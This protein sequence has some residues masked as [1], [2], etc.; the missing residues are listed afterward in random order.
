MPY[1]VE[2]DAF[3]G[4]VLLQGVHLVQ[5]AVSDEHSPVL[6]LVETVDLGNT[7]LLISHP[8]GLEHTCCTHRSKHPAE[9]WHKP[10]AVGFICLHRQMHVVTVCACG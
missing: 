9:G 7:K 4:F 1:V 2:G 6:R 8:T 3:H 5:V 10:R